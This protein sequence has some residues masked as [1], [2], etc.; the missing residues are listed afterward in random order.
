MRQLTI[1][2]RTF[3]TGNIVRHFKRETLQDPGTKYMYAIL[4]FAKHTETGEILVLYQ[5]LYED[6]EMHVNYDVFARPAEMFFSEVD[7]NKYPDIRQKFRGMA[8]RYITIIGVP[9][10]FQGKE[11]FTERLI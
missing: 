2:G 5:A 3:K 8:F 1:N 9:E 10:C 6:T 4:G 11:A 7:R